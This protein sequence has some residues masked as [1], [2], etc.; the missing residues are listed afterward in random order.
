M[1]RR[2]SRGPALNSVL[3]DTSFLITFADPHRPHHDIAEQYFRECVARR[4]PMYLSTIAASEFEV[5]QRISDLPL[6]NLI[7]LP[8]NLEHAVQCGLL[9][10]GTARDAEDDRVTFKDDLK[11]IAQCDVEGITHILTEDVHTLA[12]YVRRLHGGVF[13]PVT[14][15]ALR[16][17]FEAAWFNAGQRTLQGH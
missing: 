2:T 15:V 10:A 3:L 1:G 7:V 12:K 11:L 17:G 9:F 14:V 5:K 4:V 13:K 16:E 6:R 8:F